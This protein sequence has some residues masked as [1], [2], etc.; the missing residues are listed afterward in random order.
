LMMMMRL[1]TSLSSSSS[2]CALSCN[3][4][5]TKNDMGKLLHCRPFHIVALQQNNKWQWCA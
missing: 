3:K 1:N 5:K 4:R 2:C